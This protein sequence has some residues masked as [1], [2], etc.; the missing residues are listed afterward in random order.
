MKFIKRGF[1]LRLGNLAQ[2]GLDVGGPHIRRNALQPRVLSLREGVVKA[3]QTAGLSFARH[4]VH[5]ATRLICHHRDRV[6]SLAGGG[7]IDAYACRGS[8][9]WPPSLTARWMMPT[10]AF[11]I[12]NN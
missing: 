3:G 10:I 5:V 6:V 7:L 9:I 4:V 1:A 11:Q 2:G 8:R 12:K